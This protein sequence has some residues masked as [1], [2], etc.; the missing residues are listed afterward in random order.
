[1]SPVVD[2]VNRKIVTTHETPRYPGWIW[3]KTVFPN[4]HEEWFGT[5]EGCGYAVWGAKDK[6]GKIYGE[7]YTRRTMNHSISWEPISV[8]RKP[9]SGTMAA[10]I[11]EAE[12]RAA[13]WVSQGSTDAYGERLKNKRA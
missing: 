3:E 2:R 5:K 13:Y 8:H 4:N 6:D 12:R 7:V 1:M 11:A 9:F 10:C